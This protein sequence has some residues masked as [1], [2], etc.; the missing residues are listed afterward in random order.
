MCI[1]DSCCKDRYTDWHG[2]TEQPDK[3]KSCGAEPKYLTRIPSIVSDVVESSPDGKPGAVV[4]NHI[5]EAKEDL[6]RDKKDMSR[7]LDI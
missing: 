6:R 7:E 1:R 5:E 4:N 2:M 3:C